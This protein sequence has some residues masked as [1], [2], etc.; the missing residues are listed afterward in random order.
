MRKATDNSTVASELALSIR[1]ASTTKDPTELVRHLAKQVVWRDDSKVHVGRDEIWGALNEKWANS[2]ICLTDLQIEACNPQLIL[3]KLNS[4]WQHARCGR[5]F[6]TQIDMRIT[7][8]EQSLVSAVESTS[9]TEEISAADRELAI[10]LTPHS[11]SS[12]HS[13]SA[14]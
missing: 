13:G 2:P 12:S 11:K 3:L 5:W 9:D 7:L 6:R 1:R 14:K 8:D 4:E 10:S